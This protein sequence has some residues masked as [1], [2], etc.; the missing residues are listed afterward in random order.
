MC[1]GD[2][3]SAGVLRPLAAADARLLRRF[4]NQTFEERPLE[5]AGRVPP[6]TPDLDSKLRNSLLKSK[7]FLK[8]PRA[9]FENDPKT[10]GWVKQ[11]PNCK[12][13]S[14]PLRMSAD[15]NTTEHGHLNLFTSLKGEGALRQ[16]RL[17][18]PQGGSWRPSAVRQKCPSSKVV[19]GRAGLGASPSAHSVAGSMVG[20][21]GCRGRSRGMGLRRCVPH[22]VLGAVL[23]LLLG[24]LVG[25]T[26]QEKSLADLISTVC[27]KG[28]PPPLAYIVGRTYETMLGAAVMHL[29][30]VPNVPF[31]AETLL[32]RSYAPE[33]KIEDARF[34]SRPAP[35]TKVPGPGRTRTT[36][37]C[38]PVLLRVHPVLLDVSSPPPGRCRRFVSILHEKLYGL[39]S[40]TRFQTLR[41]CA[42]PNLAHAPPAL[43][44]PLLPAT[45]ATLD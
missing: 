35:L 42:T 40:S 5:N 3:T 45:P 33:G 34:P 23:L 24:A 9:P 10:V 32:N 4:S 7:D 18:K 12:S 22:G 26:E 21:R 30:V 38:H 41:A 28:E 2:A 37:H 8:I 31:L 1:G 27:D 29:P 25:G 43:V 13:G 36:C 20:A 19:C 16:G 17:G 6:R 44:A 15:E 11:R 14:A 39:S